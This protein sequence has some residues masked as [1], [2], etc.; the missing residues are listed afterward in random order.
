[1]HLVIPGTNVHDQPESDRPSGESDEPP[2]F[3]SG[4]PVPIY[5]L[6]A[7]RCQE[8]T[9]RGWGGGMSFFFVVVAGAL[10]VVCFT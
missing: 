3:C 1:M 5:R 10:A 7:I 4:K 8:S 2:T 6:L 9:D